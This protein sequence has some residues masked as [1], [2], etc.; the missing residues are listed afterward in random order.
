M[1]R[2]SLLIISFICMALSHSEPLVLNE[3]GTHALTPT[4]LYFA[5]DNELG[6]EEVIA[7]KDTLKW[8][9]NEDHT[10]N[11]GYFQ[12]R[13]WLKFDVTNPSI[14]SQKRL[15]EF[16]Y[17]PLDHVSLY[18]VNSS[19]IVVNH[20][21]GG[22]TLFKKD[23]KVQHPNII[24]SL[25]FPP[26]ESV[27]IYINIQSKGSL[28]LA[29]T[30]WRWQAFN[31][32][33]L[34]TY[35]LQG[36]FYGMAL[37]MLIYNLMIW[38][39]D[40]Q[41]VN[42]K[43]T[44]YISFLTIYISC[45]NGIGYFYIWPSMPWLNSV[46]PIIS[47]GL[48]MASL[49][50][51]ISDFFNAKLY[52]PKIHLYLKR[53]FNGYA[54]ITVFALF[55]SA[56]MAAYMLSSM[57]MFTLISIIIITAYMLKIKHPDA[58]YFAMAWLFMV[59]GSLLYVSSLLGLVPV[60]IFSQYG[61]Q[62]GAGIEIMFLSLAMAD[63]MARLQK[64]KN[65]ALEESIELASQVQTEQNK[66][67]SAELENLELEKQ[68]SH[69]LEKQVKEQTEEL[70][71]TLDKLSKAH[72]ALKTISITDA[73]TQLY[74]R[75][76]FDEHW[77]IEHKR[78]YRDQTPLSIIML[79]IDH[80]KKV[81]DTFGHPAGDMCLKAVAQTIKD[82]AARE[83]DI[84]CRYGGEEFVLILPGTNELGATAVAENIRK[85]IETLKLIW[86][87]KS[88]HLSASLGI[89]SLT[90]KNSQSKNR[91][92]IINQADQALYQA[93]DRGRNQVVVFDYAEN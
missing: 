45:K 89:S 58:N 63:R 51:F 81:N 72:E 83:P 22:D 15:L 24:F 43:Y 37:V 57:V 20:L 13:Y 30:L 42:L 73:L 90:P 19:G 3:Q 47:S 50:Y 41:S 53:S 78:A 62:L 9:K 92:I 68:Y 67:H 56:S 40:R 25:Q 34:L 46:L 29:F 49:N 61:M 8:Q 39:F 23:R 17:A 59:A 70:H 14:T 27:S 77:R 65:T 88:I 55:C 75:H 74:N 91:H 16:L 87:G 6:I 4:P 21:M 5:D 82:N 38:I 7:Q 2:L 10:L 33:T 52:F 18:V 60:T 31:E 84:A 66:T 32:K 36:I 86:Q 1:L 69:T 12:P 71:L 35:I 80:F 64:E 85:K 26:T 79:D 48:T 28:Q 76:Y 54:L 93:K 44:I 11:F